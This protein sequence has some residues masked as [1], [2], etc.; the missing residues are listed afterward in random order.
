[1]VGAF[2]RVALVPHHE[3]HDCPDPRRRH[4]LVYPPT[5]H[6]DPTRGHRRPHFTLQAIPWPLQ[7][8]KRLN[9]LLNLEDPLPRPLLQPH[10]PLPTPHH[11]QFAYT[12]L[13][14]LPPAALS[15]H[16][17]PLFYGLHTPDHTQITHQSHCLSVHSDTPSHILQINEF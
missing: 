12:D 17:S 15:D 9:G 11:P 1:M 10:F 3:P 16:T 2:E 13:T 7:R 14:T 4:R 6:A 5:H 8:R